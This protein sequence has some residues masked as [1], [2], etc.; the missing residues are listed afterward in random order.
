MGRLAG[1]GMPSRLKPAAGRLRSPAE[2]AAKEAPGRRSPSWTHTARWQR[3]RLEILER[4]GWLCQACDRPHMLVEGRRHPDSA[5]VDH[6]RPHRG[7]ED[8]FWDRRNLWS[9]CKRY[10]DR[11]KQSLEKGG[12]Q[13]K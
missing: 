6:R 10:H 4:D 7:D 2:D 5:V 13:S 3:L 8:L 9:V 1:R 12:R 11:V